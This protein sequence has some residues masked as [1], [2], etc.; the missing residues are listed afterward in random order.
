VEPKTTRMINFGDGRSL[1]WE[2]AEEAADWLNEQED[3]ILNDW[4]EQM[5]SMARGLYSWADMRD[6]RE[7]Y[8]HIV[9][10]LTLIKK[11]RGEDYL[12]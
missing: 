8:N 2:T 12:A 7:T 1:S 4:I 9:D 10:V 5:E 6:M 3:S 11:M